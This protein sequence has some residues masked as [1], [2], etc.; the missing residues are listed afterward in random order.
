MQAEVDAGEAPDADD[1]SELVALAYAVD[2]RY[3]GRLALRAD[4]SLCRL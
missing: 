1:R 2:I 3:A 4:I